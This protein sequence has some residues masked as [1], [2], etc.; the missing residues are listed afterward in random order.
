MKPH[1]ISQNHTKQYIANLTPIG[2]LTPCS[3]AVLVPANTIR[4]PTPSLCRHYPHAN[5][6]LIPTPLQTYAYT[7]NPSPSF[8][9]S[10]NR[11]SPL[12]TE[13]V[14]AC[15]PCPSQDAMCY[16]LHP[17]EHRCISGTRAKP[18]G[19]NRTHCVAH[20]GQVGCVQ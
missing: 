18:R 4:M 14:G 16:G 6:I 2:A 8:N 19:Q 11:F 3:L 7:F 13:L 9:L 10:L 5:T 17:T 1:P 20:W 15:C 12:G